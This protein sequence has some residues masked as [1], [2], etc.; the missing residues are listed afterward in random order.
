M[1]TRTGSGTIAVPAGEGRAVRV[2]AGQSFRVVDV[3]GGQVGDLFAFAD[4]DVSEHV[5]ASHTRARND[6]LFPAIGQPFVSNRRRPLLELV[7][8]DSPGVHDML[9]AACDGERYR[10]LGVEGWHASCAENL[11]T[12]LGALGLRAPCVPQPINVFMNVPVADGR[13]EWL[14][15]VTA[16]GD[17][18]TMRAVADV[19]VVLSACP[20]DVVHINGGQPTELAIELLGGPTP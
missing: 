15:A 3:E 5:S 2:A 1:S 19:L 18:V 6:R 7:A 13:L 4:G 8:D 20:Q 11:V 9:I 16:P 10:Q 14:P 12:A 17:S